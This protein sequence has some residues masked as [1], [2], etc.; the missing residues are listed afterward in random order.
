MGLNR[1]ASLSVVGGRRCDSGRQKI[2]GS[3]AVFLNY[4]FQIVQLFAQSDNFVTEQTN[5]G[6]LTLIHLD[7]G[8]VTDTT[9]G[10]F[11]TKRAKTGSSALG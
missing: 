2:N 11:S 9:T 6:H 3:R 4:F 10:Q 7:Q 1:A 5:D 8:V